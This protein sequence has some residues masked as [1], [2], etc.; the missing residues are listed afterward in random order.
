MLRMAEQTLIERIAEVI[1]VHANARQVYGEPIERDGMTLIP[2]AK[3]QWGFGGGTM[4][5]TGAERGGGGGGGVR[6]QPVGYIHM[7][8]GEAEFRAI[9]DPRDTAFLVAAGAAG[10]AVGLL[11]SKLTRRT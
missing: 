7:R 11:L 8:N 6:S 2:V 1:Q 9:R 10:L 5:R 4:G 3:I